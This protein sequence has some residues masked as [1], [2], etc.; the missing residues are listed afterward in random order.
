MPDGGLLTGS[1]HP[2]SVRNGW[3]ISPPVTFE[4]LVEMDVQAN[5]DGELSPRQ[6][7]LDVSGFSH[8]GIIPT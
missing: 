3:P 8:V 4:C 2:M 5:S 7:S 1:V 6:R